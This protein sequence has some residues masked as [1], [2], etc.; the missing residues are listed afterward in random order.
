MISQ[1]QNLDEFTREIDSRFKSGDD[2]CSLHQ[3]S[4]V[5]KVIRWH[6]PEG[7]DFSICGL[8]QALERTSSLVQMPM[9]YGSDRSVQSESEMTGQ[10][11]LVMMRGGH[12][13]YDECASQRIAGYD[14][15][16]VRSTLRCIVELLIDLHDRK[17]CHG[18]LKP[19]NV[20][21]RNEMDPEKHR[22]PWV[23]CDM[24]ASAKFGF[25]IG[26]KTSSAYSPPELARQLVA[27]KCFELNKRSRSKLIP[28]EP[29]FDVWSL[30]VMIF[31]LC[32][33]Q[34]LFAQVM[35]D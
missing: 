12:S 27:D 9:R 10:Y 29:T 31:E 2:Q 8:S 7:E 5:V 30:G 35:D 24:N 19:R 33:G 18:D 34:S 26:T 6:T 23:L 28:A 20:I 4:S 11:A 13:L 16:F 3:P 15:A 1:M 21:R 17:I 22:W 14:V 32:T 25:A